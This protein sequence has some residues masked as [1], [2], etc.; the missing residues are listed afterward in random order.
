MKKEAAKGSK[1]EQKAKKNNIDNTVKAIAGV[2]VTSQQDHPK[3][4][5]GAKR[6]EKRTQQEAARKQRIQDEQ[7]NIMDTASTELLKISWS[8][9]SGGSS[10]Y[11]YQ[12]LRE[13][14]AAYMRKHESDFLPFFLWENT[15]E[16][17]SDDSLAERFENYCK[18]VESTAAWGVQ[19]ELVALTHCLR[20]QIRIFS[21]SFLMWRWEKEYK[22][23]RGSSLSEG[24]LRLSYHKH[25]FGL[26]GHYNSV[27]QDLSR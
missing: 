15:I 5:K 11:T 9:L 12:E 8:H 18:E 3:P 7:S 19:L 10:S 14:A 27:I 6:R 1:A 17:D 22:S 13:M 24:T 23:D 4:S 21:G 16:G 25:V 26:G 2:F 20:K